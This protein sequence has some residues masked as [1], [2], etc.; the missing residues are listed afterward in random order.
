MVMLLLSTRFRW[1][2][3]VDLFDFQVIFFC[4]VFQDLQSY[5][6][7]K[8]KTNQQTNEQKKQ[9]AKIKTIYRDTA[10]ETVKQRER[11]RQ[12]DK[13]TDRQRENK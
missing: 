1:Q 10:T 5:V 7:R 8:D 13:Q 6:D 9:K 2:R 11:D 3:Q 12:T 4:T